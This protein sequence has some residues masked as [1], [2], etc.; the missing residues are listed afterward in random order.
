MDAFVADTAKKTNLIGDY[1]VVGS[2]MCCDDS[3]SSATCYFASMYIKDTTFT[4]TSR[5]T[6][7]PASFGM[8][9]SVAKFAA[10]LGLTS[11]S[12]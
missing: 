10:V 4:Q 12:F 5:D 7:N 3:T 9:L 1:N 11:L 8:A 6:D 2:C